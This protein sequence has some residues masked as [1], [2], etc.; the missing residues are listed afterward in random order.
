MVELVKPGEIQ[1]P[2][3]HLGDC[4]VDRGPVRVGLL[5]EHGEWWL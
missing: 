3:G 1:S 4:A 5:N 2:T